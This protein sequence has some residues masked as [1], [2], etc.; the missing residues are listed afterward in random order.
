[1]RVIA[2]A[3]FAVFAGSQIAMADLPWLT[4][5]PQALAQAK[6]E[7]KNV[8][9]DFT[10]SDWCG[11][12]MKLEKETFSKPEFLDFAQSHLVLMRIDFPRRQPL[13]ADVQ[14]VNNDLAKKYN[15]HGYPTVVELS[16]DGTVL[17]TQR[18]YLAGGPSTLIAKLE[19]VN[20]QPAVSVAAKEPVNLAA[21]F[22][23]TPTVRKPGAE[24]RLQGIFYSAHPMV[25][26][27]GKNC[28]VGDSVSGMRVLRIARDKVTVEWQG[29]TK[30]LTMN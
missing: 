8:L 11:W 4:N 7:N 30:D 10:G 9:V 20:V 16:P 24:P 19:A 13:P 27:E 17:W 12:C 23:G 28:E 21:V 29:K 14:Q 5:L 15:V 18:G 22:A 6:Q 1:M 26:L 2:H 3:L 25:L